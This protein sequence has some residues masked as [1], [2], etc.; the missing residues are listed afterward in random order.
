[1]EI[2]KNKPHLKIVWIVTNIRNVHFV[3]SRRKLQ[4]LFLTF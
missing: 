1:M 2:A 4:N 3:K